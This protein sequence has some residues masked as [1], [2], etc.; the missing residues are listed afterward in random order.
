MLGGSKD[1]DLNNRC[2]PS[3]NVYLS[4]LIAR[5]LLRESK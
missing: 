5:K 4:L 3:V 1:V 2:A